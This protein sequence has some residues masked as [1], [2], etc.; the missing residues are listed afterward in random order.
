MFGRFFGGE[1]ITCDILII[2]AV[3]ILLAQLFD[4]GCGCDRGFERERRC[5]R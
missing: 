1:T 5:C 3:I 4:G 2:I